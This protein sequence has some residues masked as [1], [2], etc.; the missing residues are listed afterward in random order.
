MSTPERPL[1]LSILIVSWNVRD[2]LLACLESIRPA[3][4][5]KHL[6]F[7]VIV[8]DGASSDGS[9]E[10]VRAR[11]P[12]VKV[13]ALSENVGFTRGNN[14]ALAQAQG[15]YLLLLN[16]DTEVIDDV[17]WAM[18]D[19]LDA[20]PDV[21][22]LGPHTF[23]G[24]RST[25][26]STRRRFPTFVTALFESTWL[27]RFAPRSLLRRFYA[28]DIADDAVAD[29]DWVQ[30]SALLLRREV[31]AKIG[32]LD[33]HYI[34]YSEELDFCKRAKLAG[35][36]VVY[37]GE[38]SIVHHGGKS[39]EQVIASRHVYFQQ[40][41]IRYFRKFHGPFVA[42]GLRTFLI[43][44][45]GEQLL[46]EAFKALLGHK[47]TLRRERVRVYWQVIRTLASRA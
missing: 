40:S 33:E 35:W 14:Q 3:W 19:Y 6:S 38:A 12:W 1:D 47:R 18:V 17:L 22:I 27:Q 39:S 41:K 44:N 24:D 8:I 23:N 21:G 13:S 28:E 34:M 26:Q 32:G 11:F 16:P 15:R 45:Y 36:R 2:Y 37:F 25:T 43:M 31:Y 29:V 9:V 42:L 30:G 5:A 4:E 7:E 10:A 20:H 46:L